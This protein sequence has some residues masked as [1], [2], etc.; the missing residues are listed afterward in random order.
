M[1]GIQDAKKPTKLLS[2]TE[3]NSIAENLLNPIE[4]IEQNIKNVI[5]PALEKQSYWVST[6]KRSKAKEMLLRV[7]NVL[8]QMALLR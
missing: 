1:T 4:K 5:I 3:L 7:F 6:D 2:D 8:Q